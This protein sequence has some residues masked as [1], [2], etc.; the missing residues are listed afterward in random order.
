MH[1]LLDH[2]AHGLHE[3]HRM[4]VFLG[5]IVSLF[6]MQTRSKRKQNVFSN[7]VNWRLFFHV[8]EL[9]ECVCNISS[10][11][12]IRSEKIYWAA[13]TSHTHKLYSDKSVQ[14]YS[15]DIY[16]LKHER[17]K[18]NKRI[19]KHIRLEIDRASEQASELE[20]HIKTSKSR[21]KVPEMSEHS[22]RS[23]EQPLQKGAQNEGER[24]KEYT[25]RY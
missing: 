25:Q 22:L 9:C 10:N 11:K 21:E 12:Q 1:F 7:G 3:K 14:N 8:F 18:S 4:I 2:F 20:M 16:I 24:Q 19:F 6:L 5:G 15:R 17:Q 13:P 23:R